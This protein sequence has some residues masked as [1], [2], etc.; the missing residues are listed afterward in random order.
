MTTT[1]RSLL[2]VDVVGVPTIPDGRLAAVAARLRVAVDRLHRAMAP[3]PL[4]VLESMFGVLDPAALTT[5]CRLDVP[6]RLTRPVTVDDLAATLEVDAASLERLLRYGAARGW[7]RID[8][9]GRVRPNRT[10]A[11]LRRSHPGGWRAWVDFLG[12]GEVAA[13]LDHLDVAL[14][15]G[16]AFHAAN[17]EP[18]FA[19][20]EAH[21]D[22]HAVFD[23]CMDAGAR[24]H[25]LV[26]SRGLDWSDTATVCDVGGGTGGVL[27]VLLA[28]HAHLRGVLVDLP[29]V[30]ARAEVVDRLTVEGGDAF[31]AVPGGADTYLFVNV[32]HDWDDDAS[33]RLLQRVVE[34]APRRVVV[35]EGLPSHPPVDDV[36]NRTDL[37]MLALTPGGRERSVAEVDEL[38][39]RA[40]LRRER[41]VPLASADVA[42]VLV[43]S[44]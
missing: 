16:D 11:F 20:M 3:P 10:T 36:P 33:V 18:F 35:V 8:R 27:H 21:P 14:H 34:R 31:A 39:R 1:P 2:P 29:A 41:T 40:G 44:A 12:S 22:R 4:Q 19:W 25:G 13:A 28:E 43:P 32:L 23:A 9:R 15:G 38:A 17:G 6:D 7:L 37:L 26:L 5:L 30:V 42:H 24:M